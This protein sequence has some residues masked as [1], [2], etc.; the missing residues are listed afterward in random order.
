LDQ[1]CALEVPPFPLTHTHIHTHKR[2][3]NPRMFGSK[4]W[5]LNMLYKTHFDNYNHAKRRKIMRLTQ[6]T[7][8]DYKKKNNGNTKYGSSCGTTPT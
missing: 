8:M 2:K 3:I 5:M 6:T 4:N 1:V 7:N